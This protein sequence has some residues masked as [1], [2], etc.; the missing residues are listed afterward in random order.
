MRYEPL[1]TT[2]QNVRGRDTAPL[3]AAESAF[4][5]HLC[6]TSISSVCGHSRLHIGSRKC[7]MALLHGLTF[8]NRSRESIRVK[9]QNWCA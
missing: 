7:K 9:M 3:R 8:S 2:L 6:Y 1:A 4:N 5:A